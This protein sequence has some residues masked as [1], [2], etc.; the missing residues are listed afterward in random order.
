MLRVTGS[1]PHRKISASL[2]FV[3]LQGA[4]IIHVGGWVFDE[5]SSASEAKINTT[6]GKVRTAVL[7][8]KGRCLLEY[9]NGIR[10]P[11]LGSFGP[12]FG[13]RGRTF[14]CVAGGGAC[15]STLMVLVKGSIVV[16]PGIDGRP[17]ESTSSRA[18]TVRHVAVLQA[19][20][21]PRSHLISLCP[22][23]QQVRERTAR[24]VQV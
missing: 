12:D 20:S 5:N 17:R 19:W 24:T 16:L 7:R 15:S 3:S 14:F 9:Y 11:V 4:P 8:L 10:I 13:P 2:R 23:L 1:K 6:R 22:L 21:C 18:P